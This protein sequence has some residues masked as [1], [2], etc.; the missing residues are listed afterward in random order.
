MTKNPS[1]RPNGHRLEVVVETLRFSIFDLLKFTV[2][3]ALAITVGRLLQSFIP[4]YSA[5]IFFCVVCGQFIYWHLIKRFVFS[6]FRVSRRYGGNTIGTG[7]LIGCHDVS[8]RSTKVGLYLSTSGMIVASILI[9]PLGP[10]GMTKL[11]QLLILSNSALMLF[12]AA[13]HSAC[14][15][16][17]GIT[18][19]DIEFLQNGVCIGLLFFP[20]SDIDIKSSDWVQPGV[21]IQKRVKRGQVKL[22]PFVAKVSLE[23]LDEVLRLANQSHPLDVVAE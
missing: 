5:N 16:L 8:K 15:E 11:P 4:I 1:S 10:I 3:V 9:V 22:N 23:T 12:M 21:V 17:K 6:L 20:W 2:V 13:Y 19:Q 14:M 7:A 18:S